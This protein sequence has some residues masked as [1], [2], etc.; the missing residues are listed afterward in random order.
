MWHNELCFDDIIIICKPV[1]PP[2]MYILENNELHIL[3]SINIEQL[4][5]IIMTNGEIVIDGHGKQ[6]TVSSSLLSRAIEQRIVLETQGIAEIN[7]D[8]MYD[9][10]SLANI[11][12]HLTIVN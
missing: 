8:A 2:H 7:E 12:I 3:W 6:L 5:T 1:L 11:V 9:T 10:T 4:E